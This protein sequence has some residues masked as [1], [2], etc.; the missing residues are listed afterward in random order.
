MLLPVGVVTSPVNCRTSERLPARA[1][2]T[3]TPRRFSAS[4][5]RAIVTSSASLT[6]GPWSCAG[7]SALAAGEL[8]ESAQPEAM[9]HANA[10]AMLFIGFSRAHAAAQ[11]GRALSR[12]RLQLR[13]EKY[14]DVDGLLPERSAGIHPRSDRRVRRCGSILRLRAGP[15]R[16]AVEGMSRLVGPSCMRQ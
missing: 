10:I 5:V 1:F 16:E 11:R 9:R 15:F 3:R 8:T 13:A 12:P 4:A 2:S 14:R 7:G 6:A